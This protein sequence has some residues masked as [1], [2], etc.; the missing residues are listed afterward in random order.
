[1]IPEKGHIYKHDILNQ[2][3]KLSWFPLLSCWFPLLTML[4]YMQETPRNQDQSSSLDPKTAT[5]S[6]T[7]TAIVETTQDEPVYEMIT[8][9][10]DGTIIHNATDGNTLDHTDNAQNDDV[11]EQTYESVY[12]IGTAGNESGE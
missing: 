10:S 9:E 8:F 1:M 3:L 4:L 5:T 7:T 6:T 12:V 2:P 11:T